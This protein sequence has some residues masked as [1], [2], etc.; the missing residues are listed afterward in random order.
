VDE[1]AVDL[2]WAEYVGSHRLT[3]QAEMRILRQ[4]Q[5]DHV[6]S[7]KK[8]YHLYLQ[9]KVWKYKRKR[10]MIR[11]GFACVKCHSEL[12]L[13]ID[14]INYPEVLGMERME[15]LQTLCWSCHKQKTKA[16]DLGA[17]GLGERL[18]VKV[19]EEQPLH[20]VLRRG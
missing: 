13:N 12:F 19:R 9:S 20:A 7:S 3:P 11:D 1:R 14:H 8:L 2:L 6:L 4:L 16:H 5:F 17:N 18:K 10:V 15:D